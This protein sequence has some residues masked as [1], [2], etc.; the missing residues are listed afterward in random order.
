MLL[1]KLFSIIGTRKWLNKLAFCFFYFLYTSNCFSQNI[2]V[3]EYYNSADTRD[4]WTELL[5]ITDNTDLRNYTLRDNNTTQTNWQNEITFANTTLWT[6][7]R[8]GTIIVIWHRLRSSFSS[9]SRL[10][11]TISTDG[12]LE[13]HAQLSGYFSGGNFG[14]APTWAGSTLSIGGS[15]DIIQ[16]KDS[17]NN[18][19]HAIGHKSTIT[20]SG[21]QFDSIVS[22][23]K[24]NLSSTISSGDNVSVCPG[25]NLSDYISGT[26]DTLYSSKGSNYITQ[27]LPN[28]RSIDSTTNQNYWRSL[29]QP[30]YNSPTLNTITANANFTQTNLSWSVCTD[31]NPS[32][33]TTGYIVLRNTINSFTYPSDN[34]VYTIG[35]IIGTAT[36]VSNINSSTTLAYT[37]IFAFTCGTTY[38]YKI[39]AFRF[40]ADNNNLSNAARGR[41]YNETGTNV[42][43]IIKSYPVAQTIIPN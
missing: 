16:I 12:Y 6:K 23:N 14:T 10:L 22:T 24:L 43:S 19:V 39:Y 29:R 28:K 38:Y 41:A 9:T 35:S 1:N 26:S 40:S 42:Q 7:L 30:I 11:D 13:V 18:H 37:D 2:V 34:I 4:E 21:N 33:S 31:L 36:V 27:G 20:N 3:S 25:A 32:D 17:S 8:A 5:V 15:G